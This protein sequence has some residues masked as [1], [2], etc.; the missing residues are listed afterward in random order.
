MNTTNLD[1][2]KLMAFEA[3]NENLSVAEMFLRNCTDLHQDQWKL[4]ID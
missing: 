1:R 2:G 4:G 3:K